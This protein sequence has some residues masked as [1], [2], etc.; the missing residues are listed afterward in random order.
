[1]LKFN[2][3]NA[4]Q[5]DIAKQILKKPLCAVWL[6]AGL[7]KTIT[8]LTAI[9][10][11]IKTGRSKKVLVIAP[12]R[13]A[14][15]VWPRELS[16]WDFLADLKHSVI[17][18]EK[19]HYSSMDE[20][21]KES[22]IVVMSSTLLTYYSPKDRK[23][24]FSISFIKQFDT[25]IVDE[26]SM[27][28]NNSSVRTKLIGSIAHNFIRIIQLTATPYTNSSEDVFM[29]MRML[30]C[31]QIGLNVTEFRRNYM[32]RVG[33][34][35]TY[36]DKSP[37]TIKEVIHLC[38]DKI[39]QMDKRIYLPKVIHR[40]VDFVMTDYHK[41]VYKRF[42][43]DVVTVLENGNLLDATRSLIKLRQLAC[44][45]IYTE[46]GTET[47]CNKRVEVLK[48]I[49]EST[50]SNC[51]AVYHFNEELAMIKKI[52]PYA[53][54]FRDT[55]AIDKWN[56]KKIKL[57]LIHPN[58]AG[59]GLN[60][61]YGGN[62]MIWSSPSMGDYERFHKTNARIARIGGSETAIY[63]HILAKG[64]VDKGLKNAIDKK[65]SNALEVIR[66]LRLLKQSS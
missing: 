29:Q 32:E 5:L 24:K 54:D 46:S 44:G 19:K 56:N 18:G 39:I 33:N 15:E 58:S 23:T 53:V 43:D 48:E 64:T 8:V 45:F 65:V 31:H 6:E 30:R 38:S 40:E 27:Y 62:V 49:V 61:Q 22:D 34:Y 41:E 28:K 36:K 63:H 25:L 2:D 7:G 35:Y 60:L 42:N 52:L 21:T 47:I 10:T 17:S 20:S 11:L 1:M 66:Y 3:L 26:S 16:S 57:L 4:Y 37:N 51:I 12:P 50:N 55:G 59:H 9:K 14:V 13:V